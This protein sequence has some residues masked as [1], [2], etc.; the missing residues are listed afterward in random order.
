MKRILFLL[1]ASLPAIGWVALIFN[2][3]GCE[4]FWLVYRIA[5]GFHL[6]IS[7]MIGL[8]TAAFLR[9]LWSRHPGRW[10]FLTGSLAWLAGLFVMGLLDLT[11]LCVGQDN[12]DGNNDLTRCVVVDILVSLVYTPVQGLAL[13]V[14]SLLGSRILK[15]RI[16]VLR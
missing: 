4:Y 3:T 16:P 9:P 12:G 2:Q 15:T 6:G 5:A 7:V 10:I 13:G 14:I 8:F 11:P 1:F